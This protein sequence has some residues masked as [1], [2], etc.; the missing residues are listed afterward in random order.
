MLG[1]VSLM[2]DTETLVLSVDVD[3]RTVKMKIIHS[4]S[5]K[6]HTKQTAAK[7]SQD[8]RMGVRYFQPS[9]RV[10]AKARII[11]FRQ[12]YSFPKQNNNA[13]FDFDMV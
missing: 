6:I 7:P 1:P 9:T 3:T 11:C 12:T 13:V 10:S 2:T 4:L 5:L 8:P